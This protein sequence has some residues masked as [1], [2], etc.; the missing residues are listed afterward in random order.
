VLPPLLSRWLEVFAKL[1]GGFRIERH[2]FNGEAL[3]SGFSV[4][5]IDGFAAGLV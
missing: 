1:R 5:D 4:A 3:R 2:E